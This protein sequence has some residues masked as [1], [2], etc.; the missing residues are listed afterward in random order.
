M[1][2]SNSTFRAAFVAVGSA[3]ALAIFYIGWSWLN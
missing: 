1:D 2:K 3:I